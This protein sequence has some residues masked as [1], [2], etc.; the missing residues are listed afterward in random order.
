VGRAAPGVQFALSGC[1]PLAEAGTAEAA[2]S[3][4]ELA[5][6]EATE[7]IGGWRKCLLRRFV[8]VFL[9]VL[10]VLRPGIDVRKMQIGRTWG[11]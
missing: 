7:G 4:T 2:V 9:L 1:G 8:F 5:D 6:V 10:T 3:L 11:S